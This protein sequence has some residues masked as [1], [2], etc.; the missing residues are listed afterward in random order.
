MK[1]LDGKKNIKHAAILLAQLAGNHA[2]RAE[3]PLTRSTPLWR[4]E[5]GWLVTLSLAAP[6]SSERIGRNQNVAYSR[7]SAKIQAYNH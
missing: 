5:W 7:H 1:G 6:I 4:R 2:S 3:T